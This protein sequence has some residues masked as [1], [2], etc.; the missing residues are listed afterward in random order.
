MVQRNEMCR[1]LFAAA[2][3]LGSTMNAYEEQKKTPP[4]PAVRIFNRAAPNPPIPPDMFSRAADEDI[5]GPQFEPPKPREP[6]KP[7]KLRE[8]QK[9]PKKAQASVVETARK[10]VRRQE[11]PRVQRSDVEVVMR[12][13]GEKVKHDLEVLGPNVQPRQI[14]AKFGRN[15]PN[16]IATRQKLQR[17]LEVEL[18]I[19]GRRPVTISTSTN[20]LEISLARSGYFEGARVEGDGGASDS[21]GEKPKEKRKRKAKWAEKPKRESPRRKRS[22][23]F[24]SDDDRESPEKPGSSDD[25]ERPLKVKKKKPPVRK[26]EPRGEVAFVSSD[27]F[28]GPPQK[29]KK[30]APASFTLSD[31]AEGPPPKPVTPQSLAPITLMKVQFS[32][33]GGGGE[34]PSPDPALRRAQT[35]AEALSASDDA[36]PAKRGATPKKAERRTESAAPH[37]PEP[38]PEPR[39]DRT[40]TNPRSPATDG[41]FASSGTHS[42]GSS[43]KASQPPAEAPLLF[44]SS[45]NDGEYLATGN[46]P[47]S[48]DLFSADD[49]GAGG[50]APVFEEEE[51]EKWDS[52]VGGFAPPVGPPTLPAFPQD[53]VHRNSADRL[54]D[55]GPAPKARQP[56]T[57]ILSDSDSLPILPELMQKPARA[58]DTDSPRRGLKDDS[59][60]AVNAGGSNAIIKSLAGGDDG[61]MLPSLME[62]DDS[63]LS[64]TPSAK[65]SREQVSV[66]AS[67]RLLSAR[68]KTANER[69]NRSSEVE[70]DPSFCIST[71]SVSG[72]SGSAAELR[73]PKSRKKKGPAPV[74]VAVPAGE[75]APERSGLGLGHATDSS[76]ATPP[77]FTRKGD[78]LEQ[79]FPR[80]DEEL[81]PRAQKSK[82][83]L[84]FLDGKGN[85]HTN[86]DFGSDDATAAPIS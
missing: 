76:E 10:F 7:P 56:I 60:P 14:A 29:P 17:K 44:A 57:N 33:S 70:S 3:E 50:P 54:S 45:D 46:A 5:V 81:S 51:E 8:P 77:R 82:T 15:D 53:R 9:P 12:E 32:S 47:A 86:Q 65:R 19:E 43:S 59:P 63:D 23:V 30:R 26:V 85:R 40:F 42:P 13:I 39:D 16:Y 35:A 24:D 34:P 4:K 28:E 52:D 67:A 61:S 27:D 55:D 41:A 38:E 74:R 6:Q 69:G 71:I 80:E 79:L 37:S 48:F 11:S 72:S 75:K 62:L 58:E 68:G 49:E 1:Q 78:E 2:D 73:D 36:A 18:P 21:D 22:S 83:R 64:P 25:S 84:T 31:D 20:G 66:L